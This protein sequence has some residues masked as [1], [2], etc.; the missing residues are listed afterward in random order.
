MNSC[1]ARSADFANKK[2]QIIG[3]DDLA[4]NL[5]NK[6]GRVAEDQAGGRLWRIKYVAT[7]SAVS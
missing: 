2:L 4:Q 6:V 7:R 1:E 3:R 5:V